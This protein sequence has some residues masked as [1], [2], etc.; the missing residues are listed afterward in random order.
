MA[1]TDTSND[2]QLLLATLPPA[3]SE[4]IQKANDQDNLLEIVMDLGRLPEAR[5]RGH[6]L[7]LSDREVTVE[8][9]NYVIARIG[10]FGEDNRAGIPRTLHRISGIRNR[11]GVVIGLTCRVGRAV[12][13]TV[14]IIRDLVETGQSILLLGKP[15]TGKT[16][17]LRET[18]RVLGD[19]LRKRV[20]IVDT[21]NEI[22]GDGDIPHPGIGRARR[23]Q[24]PRPAEQHNV[25]IEAVEN[26][27]PEVI[28][29]D[30]I[31]TELEAAA[32]RTI[33]E[34]GVQLVGTA[35]G[36]TL[37]NLMINPTLSDLVGGIQAVTLGDEEARRRGTQKTVLERKAPPTFSILVE[38]QSWDSVTVYPDVAAA[39]DAI[40]RGE[41][42]PCERRFREP[43]GTVRREPARRATIDA[44][45]FGGRRSRG[46]REQ[47]QMGTSGPRLRDRNGGDVSATTMMPPQRIFPF[48]VSRNRLQNAIERLRVPAVIVRDL[49]DATLV[50]TLKNYYR[51]S[52]QQ[53]RQAEEQGVPVYV[54]RNNTITQMERQLAQVFQLREII[55]DEAPLPASGDSVIEEALLETEQA[56]TQVINGERSAVELTPRSSYIRR[57]QHQMAGRYNLRSES[58]GDDPNRRVKI[59]R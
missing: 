5:Y 27:M 57:L 36:N 56:I 59:F 17:L 18:A 16:T 40:L 14:D 42:P 20:V 2:I 50:M 26:H 30:E 37:D 52:S 32:A 43:N 28:V 22:A 55:D 8:D 49:K 9:I 29:I 7:F 38:I 44:P 19:E 12:F 45:A 33:A 13:G 3:I 4:A 46:G 23:M 1:V 54:L 31:G 51:Q 24:V 21:S 10:E 25:M 41:E 58:R 35:H 34:R 39:V 11:R 53:L 15:G 47:A 48:G 6:E